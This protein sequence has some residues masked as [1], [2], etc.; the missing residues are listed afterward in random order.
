LHREETTPNSIEFGKRKIPKNPTK[1][2][3]KKQQTYYVSGDRRSHGKNGK[4]RMM[5]VL[6]RKGTRT[7]HST[8][9]KNRS[10]FGNAPGS[11]NP[12]QKRNETKVGG[13]GGF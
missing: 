1:W 4:E 3:E 8:R 10:C 9:K 11:Y 7:F 13:G 6:G 5:E 12:V 2:K